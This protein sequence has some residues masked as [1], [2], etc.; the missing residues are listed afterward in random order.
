MKQIKIFIIALTCLLL[1]ITVI[2]VLNNN[3][4]RSLD[5]SSI[6]Q[7]EQAISATPIPYVEMTIPYLRRQKYDSVMGD[8]SEFEKYSEYIS[9]LTSYPSEGFKINGLAVDPTIRAT[10]IL[11]RA[12]F[13]YEDMK[14]Y[15]L[16][17]NSY[18][19]PT[20]ITQRTNRRSEM[21][22]L[23]G[24]FDPKSEFWRRVSPVNYIAEPVGEIQLHH[25]INDEVVNVE[26]SEDLAEALESKKVSHEIFEYEGGGHNIEGYSFDIAMQRTVDFFKKNLK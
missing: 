9:Y 24:Q 3:R 5:Q 20:Q 12:V 11:A 25:A 6:A 13:T 21:F 22:R 15:G 19:P 16:S 7:S 18:R 26:Y 17:D 23:H 14:K 1:V 8:R 2:L 4:S 10:V